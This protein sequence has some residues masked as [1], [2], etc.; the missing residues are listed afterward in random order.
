MMVCLGVTSLRRSQAAG[1]MQRRHDRVRRSPFGRFL[2]SS[3]TVQ[4]SSPLLARDLADW[5]LFISCSGAREAVSRDCSISPILTGE[6]RPLPPFAAPPISARMAA[7][8][9]LYS[10]VVQRRGLEAR[11]ERAMS[12]HRRRAGLTLAQ[13]SDERRE[14]WHVSISQR[15][16]RRGRT[17][18]DPRV[19]A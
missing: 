12:I 17:S 8:T 1:E 19:G 13:R 7:M 5:I 4:A 2:A 10:Q 9:S 18:S 14:H 16:R 11:D 15:P 6:I 3:S